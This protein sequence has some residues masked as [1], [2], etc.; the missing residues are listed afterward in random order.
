L[1]L[2]ISG[3][4][5]ARITE[6]SDIHAGKF[7]LNRLLRIYPLY[8]TFILVSLFL[9]PGDHPF[10]NLVLS[11]ITLPNLAMPYWPNSPNFLTPHLW[12]VAVEFQIYLLFPVILAEYR[13]KGLKALF[14]VLAATA[15]IKSLAFLLNGTVCSLAAL[16]IFGRLD[17]FIVGAIL[18]YSF[19]SL[20]PRLRNP[21]YLLLSV[22]IVLVTL[23]VFHLHGGSLAMSRKSIWILW[24]M[25]E[26]LA[27]GSLLV[28]YCSS[29]FSYPKPI[30]RALSFLGAI[31]YS[32]YVVHF[33]II[34]IIAARA[35]I[36]LYAFNRDV[37][38][39]LFGKSQFEAFLA[40]VFFAL[41]VILPV[42]AIF[43]C[44]TYFGIEKPFMNRRVKYT[45]LV[46]QTD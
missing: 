8:L 15:A 6:K 7:L 10:E 23:G 44:V 3:F 2:T 32:L 22:G 11:A 4:L 41:F 42:T 36:P 17:Q 39:P 38:I 29:T 27:W 45:R 20:Q 26:S 5:F 33:P 43:S 24:P 28:A 34:Q 30:M 16:T 9:C 12:T 13:N 40:T 19:K 46:P 35:C 18:G 37:L 25:I 21:I 1:F 31:S 14:G